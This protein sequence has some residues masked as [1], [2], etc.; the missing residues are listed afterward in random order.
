MTTGALKIIFL[1]A[2]IGTHGVPCG[3]AWRG[4]NIEGVSGI[5]VK[6]RQK[7]TMKEKIMKICHK[8]S[9]VKG[10]KPTIP[11]TLIHRAGLRLSALYHSSEDLPGFTPPPPQL[12]DAATPPTDF[13]QNFSE[14]TYLPPCDQFLQLSFPKQRQLTRSTTTVVRPKSFQEVSNSHGSTIP[15]HQFV[16]PGKSHAGFVSGPTI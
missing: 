4:S 10:Q 6:T 5:N 13:R 7:K 2:D 16:Q 11:L 15:L 3:G 8:E 12:T 9:S 14:I 1:S